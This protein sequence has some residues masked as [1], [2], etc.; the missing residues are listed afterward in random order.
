MPAPAVDPTAIERGK[1]LV[2]A[3]HTIKDAA[4]QVGVGYS[5]LT[6]YL[7]QMRHADERARERARER[8]VA[9]VAADIANTQPR[10]V[11]MRTIAE[12]GPFKNLDALLDSLRGNS[13]PTLHWNSLAV[14]SLIW[15][16]QK[17]GL[18]SLHQRQNGT[19]HDITATRN[20]Y[21]SLGYPP[22]ATGPRPRPR[23]NDM[24]DER[25]LPSV[26]PGGPVERVEP[27]PRRT[28]DRPLGE[29]GAYVGRDENLTVHSVGVDFTQPTI[30][31][32]ETV[33]VARAVPPELVEF[34]AAVAEGLSADEFPILAS[35]R[36]RADNAA[37]ARAA[38]ALIEQAADLLPDADAGTALIE[39]AVRALDEY[40]LSDV[41]AEYLRFAE[42]AK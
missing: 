22:G 31:P 12:R 36:E 8:D 35:L 2:D 25:N 1:A 20:L 4:A 16:M 7:S 21:R 38:V 29:G 13:P 17:A 5:T 24:T 33:E 30:I 27:E 19:V 11:V 26:A 39:Q 9:H 34:A 15:S 32:D 18:V 37:K 14:T 40:A 6:R 28:T 3:G 42:G 23:P 10:L 41:E